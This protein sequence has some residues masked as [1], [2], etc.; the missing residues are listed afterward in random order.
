MSKLTYKVMQFK[1]KIK[2]VKKL[3]HQK[4]NSTNIARQ[5]KLLELIRLAIHHL[6]IR[7]CHWYKCN[8]A[9]VVCIGNKTNKILTI[10]NHKSFH[11]IDITLHIHYLGK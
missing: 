11:D 8:K 3:K 4:K 5:T 1:E 6:Y 9:Q 7:N 2:L 10:A